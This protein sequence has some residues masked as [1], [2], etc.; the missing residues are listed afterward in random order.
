M[1]LVVDTNRLIAALV[2]DSY[3]RRVLFSDR[4][5]FYTI[6]LSRN[7]IGK[8]QEELL[9]KSRLTLSQFNNLIDW[10]FDYL[11]VIDVES[12]N[13]FMTPAGVVMDSIDPNDSPFIAAALAIKADGIWTHDPHFD[14]QT[15]VKIIRTNDLAALL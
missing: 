12:V 15:L 2:K 14:H 6:D 10:L 1:K 5:D 13:K 8:Y 3:S 11:T 9:S 4:F 7:E